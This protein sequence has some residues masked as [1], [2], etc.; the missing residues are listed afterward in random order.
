MKTLPEYE[1]IRTK[2]RTIELRI[3]P[4]ARLVVRAPLH[5]PEAH[6]RKLI[7]EKENWIRRHIDHLRLT[8]TRPVRVMAAAD[9]LLRRKEAMEVFRARAE[10]FASSMGVRFHSL[11]LSNAKGRW[12]SCAPG[13]RV[14]L[15][16]RLVFAPSDVL[17]YVIVHELAHLKHADHSPRFWHEVEKV[18]PDHKLRRRWLRTHQ[19]ELSVKE[20]R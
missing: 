18:L 4:D 19:A 14:R 10:F 11:A 12:G 3:T 9:V 15:N 20:E 7:A 17:D 16:W 5:A 2:R 13:G 6:I 1:T 8:V